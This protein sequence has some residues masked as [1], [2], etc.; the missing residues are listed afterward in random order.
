MYAIRSYYDLAAHRSDWVDTLTIDYRGYTV[1]ELPP[2]G[3]GIVA[4]MALGMLE[5]FDVASHP[6]D[7]PDSVHL[8][9]EAVKLAFADAQAYVADIDYMPVITSYSIH[10]T[11]LYDANSRLRIF[12]NPI[13]PCGRNSVTRMNSRPRKYSQYSGNATVNTL[14]SYNFV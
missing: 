1:H 5:N 11:K 7:S 4:L 13:T 8:Q 10:Y 9:I 14:L 6:V 2:N 12:S 3:Q